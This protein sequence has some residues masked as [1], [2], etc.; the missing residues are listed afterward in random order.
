MRS[1]NVANQTI[2][3]NLSCLPSPPVRVKGHH[4][5]H[6]RVSK[7]HF[8]TSAASTATT[9]TAHVDGH[10]TR[11]VGFTFIFHVSL[12]SSASIPASAS[13]RNASTLTYPHTQ[14]VCTQSHPPVIRR[15]VL[16]K[17]LPFLFSYFSTLTSITI[18]V[19]TTH[20]QRSCTQSRPPAVLYP[21][22]FFPL[23]CFLIYLPLTTICIRTQSHAQPH[24]H[25]YPPTI[26]VQ[27]HPHPPPSTSA[28]QRVRMPDTHNHVRSPCVRTQALRRS[29]RI[30]GPRV[31]YIFFYLIL[32]SM[33]LRVYPHAGTPTGVL[34]RPPCWY[35]YPW[36]CTCA[37]TR[38]CIA[39]KG[40]PTGTGAGCALETRGF[41]RALAYLLRI[42]PVDELA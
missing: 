31:S 20:M 29:N 2:V 32:I 13:L 34:C 5:R 7:F 14:C 18:Y 30:A 24:H 4:H 25:P 9:T 3:T 42:L 11:I 15:T 39:G 17:F 22:S 38:V 21:V 33:Y 26:H 19:R 16:R 37:E 10:P 1:H 35:P 27:P 8:F 36:V 41:T 6:P 23:S 28:R 12:P 40:Y